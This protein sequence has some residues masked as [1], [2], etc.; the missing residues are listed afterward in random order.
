MKLMTYN[1]L[2]GGNERLST[3]IEI[4]KKESPDYL[5]INEAN[6]FAK[7]NNKILKE[8]ANKTSFRFFDIALSGEYDYHVAVFSKYPF[9]KIT[10]L[11]PLMRACLV[12]QIDSVFGELS[13]AS[14]HLTPYTEDLRHPEI[15]RIVEYQKK[16]QNR[17]LMGDIN[18]LSRQDNYD[19]GMIKDFNDMQIK[20]FTTD[21]KLRFDAIEKI[22]NVGYYDC[23]LEMGKNKESTAPTSINEYEAHSNMRLDYVFLSKTLLPHLKQYNVIKNSLTEKASDHYPVSVLLE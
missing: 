8:V 18:S 10:K 13:I 22:R 3:I 20:K 21:D 6:T 12:A 15:D 7:D 19:Q 1:I 11:Q 16:F 5:T 2:N 9:K 23:A 14:L 17:I 4:I